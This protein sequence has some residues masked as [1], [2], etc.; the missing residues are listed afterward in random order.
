MPECPCCNSQWS[1][2][3]RLLE[4]CGVTFFPNEFDVPCGFSISYLG[5][6]GSSDGELYPVWPGTVNHRGIGDWRTTVFGAGTNRWFQ[7]QPSPDWTNYGDHQW[8]P[9]GF[10]FKLDVEYNFGDL[11][12]T[13]SLHVT[14]TSTVGAQIASWT[15]AAWDPYDTRSAGT[16]ILNDDPDDA[17]VPDI[18]ISNWHI[19]TPSATYADVQAEAIKQ[20]IPCHF[21]HNGTNW[22]LL[23]G[24]KGSSSGPGSTVTVS[25]SQSTSFPFTWP[26]SNYYDGASPGAGMPTSVTV[27]PKCYK[28]R[29]PTVFIWSECYT[30][31]ENWLTGYLDTDVCVSGSSDWTIN[32]YDGIDYAPPADAREAS[33]TFNFHHFFDSN[34]DY[35][36]TINFKFQVLHSGT[37]YLLI[38]ASSSSGVTPGTDSSVW[39]AYGGTWSAGSY[40]YGDWVTYNSNDKVY[41][42]SN[43]SGTSEIPTHADWAYVG[44]RTRIVEKTSDTCT[45]DCV[46]TVYTPNG[47]AIYAADAFNENSEPSLDCLDITLVPAS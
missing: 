8:T 11:D 44:E 13:L 21:W 2:E 41:M 38:N 9:I 24:D 33:T 30:E 28:A 15:L 25:S 27:T 45:G 35:T 12:W 43:V 26:V 36:S 14:T 22:V 10:L 46:G 20:K 47:Y 37:W 18:R 39:R 5:I 7:F 40:N 32:G 42:V 23:R 4:P 29:H 16:F 6:D 31:L 3:N 1:F 34:Y 17:E 19:F